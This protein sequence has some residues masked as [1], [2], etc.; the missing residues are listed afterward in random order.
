MMPDSGGPLPAALRRQQFNP[1]LAMANQADVGQALQGA[2]VNVFNLSVR[3]VGGMTAV[4]GSVQSEDEKRKAEQAIE[5]RVGKI[6]NHLEVEVKSGSG[7]SYTVKSGD[8]LSKIA[9]DIYGD[10]SQ[11]KKIQEANADLIRDPDKI[12]AGWTLNLPA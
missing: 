11:W 8:T 9:K 7:R 12:Q 2:G 1:E 10:A 3:D 4:Y 5:A 6:S